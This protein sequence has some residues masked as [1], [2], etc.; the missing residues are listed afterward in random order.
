M[1]YTTHFIK[2]YINISNTVKEKKKREKSG[3]LTGIDLK[4]TE[5]QPPFYITGLF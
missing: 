5:H 3:L 1:T 4:L 2:D